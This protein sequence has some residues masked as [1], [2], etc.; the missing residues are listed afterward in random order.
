MLASLAGREGQWERRQAGPIANLASK[1]RDCKSGDG[2]CRGANKPGHAPEFGLRPGATATAKWHRM[3]KS[4]A[5]PDFL[6]E[7]WE[8]VLKMPNGSSFAGPS[9]GR[10]RGGKGRAW[11]PQ[12]LPQLLKEQTP[13]TPTTCP[14]RSAKTKYKRCLVNRLVDDDGSFQS[15]F[16]EGLRSA[17]TSTK[18]TTSQER[19]CPQHPTRICSP[20]R[21]FREP[22]DA[23]CDRARLC[24]ERATARQTTST[25]CSNA[26]ICP[27]NDL[28]KPCTEHAGQRDILHGSLL[29]WH[30]PSAD[31]WGSRSG[32]RS[33]T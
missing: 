28:A 1:L 7:A 3:Y 21:I 16:Y 10:F 23:P 31:R 20:V 30:C 26:S 19:P 32:S 22:V 15:A 13:P 25:S 9:R 29:Q 4:G 33:F 12:Q 8:A 27:A 14:E 24:S 5:L 18:H 6:V 17:Y 11:S 2:P